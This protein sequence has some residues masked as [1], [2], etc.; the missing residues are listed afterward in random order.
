M[1]GLPDYPGHLSTRLSTK[2][3]HSFGKHRLRFGA[4]PVRVS[5]AWHA[6]PSRHCMIASE[7]SESLRRRSHESPTSHQAPRV[8]AAPRVIDPATPLQRAGAQPRRMVPSAGLTAAAAPAAM[9]SPG[10]G[11]RQPDCQDPANENTHSVQ[12]VPAKSCLAYATRSSRRRDQEAPRP[13]TCSS[14]KHCTLGGMHAP[15]SRSLWPCT[16]RLGLRYP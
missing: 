8:I 15:Y 9:T 14:G 5:H 2:S 11:W 16:G 1:R 4:A 13:P 3:V 6:V 7:A 10:P 12:R